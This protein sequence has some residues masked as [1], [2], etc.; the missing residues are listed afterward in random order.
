[1][2]IVSGRHVF[3]SPNQ[4]VVGWRGMDIEVGGTTFSEQSRPIRVERGGA[5]QVTARDRQK[6]F[7]IGETVRFSPHEL[8]EICFTYVLQAD[9]LKGALVDYA[10]ASGVVVNV[11]EPATS[12][13]AGPG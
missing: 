10:R 4:L 13:E 1:M 2:G 9:L 5:V 6:A 12:P 7:D 11:R 8:H 3:G